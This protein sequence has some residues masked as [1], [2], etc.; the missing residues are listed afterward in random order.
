MLNTWLRKTFSKHFSHLVT[1]PRYCSSLKPFFHFAIFFAQLDEKVDES[2]FLPL[3]QNEANPLEPAVHWS[4]PLPPASLRAKGGQVCVA[5]WLEAA[6]STWAS[7]WFLNGLQGGWKIGWTVRIEE[8]WSAAR[9]PS[10][11]SLRDQWQ[12]Q[13]SFMSSLTWTTAQS[14]LPAGSR[15]WPN[16]SGQQAGEHSATAGEMTQ[17]KPPKAQ[18]KQPRSPA[19]RLWYSQKTGQDEADWRE[20][21]SAEK[22]QGPAGQQVGQEPVVGP[23]SKGDQPHLELC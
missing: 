10:S 3:C 4:R 12:G 16:R 17:H 14:V 8:L 6:S 5:V 23:C 22:I 13:Y 1:L 7:T 20:S 2:F 9:S 21:R 11:L 19:T 18:Q 15:V